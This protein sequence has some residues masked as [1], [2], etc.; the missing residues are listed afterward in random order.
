MKLE[1]LSSRVLKESILHGTH[2]SGLRVYIIPKK[3]FCKYYA[4]YG[5]EYGSVDDVLKVPG[6]NEEIR[7]PYG[8]SHFL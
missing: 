2:E 4:I 7:L 6:I 1:K 3:G 8:I 5:T